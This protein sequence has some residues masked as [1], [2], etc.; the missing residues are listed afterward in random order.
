MNY[1]LSR[2]HTVLILY[3][4]ILVGRS[5][6]PVLNG[7]CESQ[8]LKYMSTA[9][10]TSTYT[11]CMGVHVKY[12]LSQK[13]II[14][15]SHWYI[16][17][18]QPIKPVL[19]GFCESQILRIWTLLTRQ[20]RIHFACLLTVHIGEICVVTETHCCGFTLIYI[21]KPTH[22]TCFEWILWKSH[23]TYMCHCSA[24]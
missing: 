14:A 3:W 8:I 12:V 17:V 23:F 10:A 19:N 2:K 13:H 16:S 18:K 7:F 21:G 15:V 9:H 6:K 24:C 11:L 20:I 5:Y 22:L 4:Y 1:L